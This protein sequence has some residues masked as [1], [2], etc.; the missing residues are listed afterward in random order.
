MV[1][2]VTQEYPGDTIKNKKYPWE[3]SLNGSLQKG[4]IDF[5]IEIRKI[6]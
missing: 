2:G 4:T 5:L 1:L 3:H 6:N